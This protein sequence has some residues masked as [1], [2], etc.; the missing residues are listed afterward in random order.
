MRETEPN[1]ESKVYLGLK[2]S[3]QAE[4]SE[5]GTFNASSMRAEPGL[6]S[7]HQHERQK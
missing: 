1:A 6:Y 5:R 3:D 2:I 4:E 7:L